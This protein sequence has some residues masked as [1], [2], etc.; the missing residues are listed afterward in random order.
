M[1]KI[2]RDIPPVSEMEPQLGMLL[3]MLDEGTRE[4]RGEFEEL[5]ELSTEAI[6]W[7]P[8]SDS[9]SIG[10]LLLHIMEVEAFWI[11]EIAQKK[12]LT[13]DEL[14]ALVA[15]LTN[16]DDVKWRTPPAE[17]MVWYWDQFEQVRVRSREII[18]NF[19]DP[20]LLC[21]LPSLNREYSLRWILHH[22]VAHEA[23]HGGQAVFLGLLHKN[24]I[25]TSI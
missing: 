17:S 8:F 4:W 3:S 20:H 24:T 6:T 12:S 21:A 14:N 18:Q 2:V 7:Q 5:G 25:S 9:H 23:Y 19:T 11:H 1:N 15:D 10:G 16:V 13:E 22:V